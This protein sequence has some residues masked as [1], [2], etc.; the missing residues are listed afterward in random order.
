MQSNEHYT[1][2]HT[3]TTLPGDKVHTRTVKNL[4]QRRLTEVIGQQKLEGIW[5]ADHTM[6]LL[7]ISGLVGEAAWFASCLGDWK[8]AFLLSVTEQ[9]RQKN[10]LY[11]EK[12]TRVH[13]S[14][15][16]DVPEPEQ[17]MKERINIVLKLDESMTV[18]WHF[19]VF[20][21]A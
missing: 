21:R 2:S 8:I 6:E 9:F 5:T 1:R 13:A 16:V 10:Q 15:P 12:T 18:G 11:V 20:I 19:Y 14:M 7:L 3:F 17:L 4:S